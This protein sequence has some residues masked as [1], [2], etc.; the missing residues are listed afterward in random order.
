MNPQ[1]E[2]TAQNS[3]KVM[4]SGVK[5]KRRLCILNV[6]GVVVGVV[7]GEE[8]VVEGRNGVMDG[9]EDTVGAGKTC[10]CVMYF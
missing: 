7:G 4:K 8:G 2:L 6:G 3:Q 5:P 10:Y 9:D 1:K